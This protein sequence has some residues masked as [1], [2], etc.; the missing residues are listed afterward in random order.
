MFRR[1]SA[2]LLGFFEQV[3]APNRAANEMI[4]VPEKQLTIGNEAALLYEYS[5]VKYVK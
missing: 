2:H 3:L 4:K 5:R 1:K